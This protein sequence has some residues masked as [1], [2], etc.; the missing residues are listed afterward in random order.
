MHRVY[1]STVVDISIPPQSFK[2]FALLFL[3]SPLSKTPKQYPNKSFFNP[4]KYILTS[5]THSIICFIIIP[6]FVE[7]SKFLF[8]TGFRN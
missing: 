4:I 6:F 7:R 2:P 5:F 1:G 3:H 8:F